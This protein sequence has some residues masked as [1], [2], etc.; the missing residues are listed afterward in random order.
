MNE[1]EHLM[2]QMSLLKEKLKEWK[3]KREEHRRNVVELIQR[4]RKVRRDLSALFDEL[5]GLKEKKNNLISEISIL[6]EERNYSV[7]KMKEELEKARTLKCKVKE[8]TGQGIG[9]VE[10]IKRKISSIEWRIQ[11]S[12]LELDDERREFNRIME[13]GNRLSK[14]MAFSVL[15]KQ[16]IE[17]YAVTGKWKN[18]ID[19][20]N[21]K[22]KEKKEEITRCNCE[23]KEL[24]GRILRLKEEL[25]GL[26]R[27]IDEEKKFLREEQQAIMEVTEKIRVIKAKALSLQRKMEAEREKE[28]LDRV[29]AEARKKLKEKG[30]LSFEEYSLLLKE[31][32]L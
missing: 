16:M 8:L 7:K 4:K 27:E 28:V 14:S 23:I 10:D 13:L 26:D 3:K 2:R 9:H 19:V 22:I 24:S 25:N 32:Y 29:L 17:A 21:R 1:L 5:K 11:T 20:L 18:N 6:R 30:K 15:K 12:C 31:G